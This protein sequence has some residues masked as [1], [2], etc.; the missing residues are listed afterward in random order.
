[1]TDTFVSLLRDFVDEGSTEDMIVLGKMIAT[2]VSDVEEEHPEKVQHLLNK[3]SCYLRPFKCKT[4]VEDIVAKFKN[5]DGSTGAHWDYDTVTKVAQQEGIDNIPLFFYVLNMQYSDYF[6]SGYSDSDYI[7]M[8]KQ[9][10]NDK[11]APEDKAVRYY[12]AMS[13]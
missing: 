10:I 11:D 13:Y 5:A 8:A 1:M 6:Y 7:R 3:M 4:R 12:R 9:Y 2:F